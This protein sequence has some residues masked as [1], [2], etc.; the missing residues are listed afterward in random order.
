MRLSS[1]WTL[2]GSLAQWALLGLVGGG[3]L[4]T[5]APSWAWAK[6][7]GKAKH[8]RIAVDASGNVYVTRAASPTI[9]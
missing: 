5:Q 8:S 2:V 3:R 9:A 4:Y 7:V 6:S 1:L